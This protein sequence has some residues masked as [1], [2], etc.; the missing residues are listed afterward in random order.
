MIIETADLTIKGYNSGKGVK[1]IHHSEKQIIKFHQLR[2]LVIKEKPI[3][4][5]HCEI[6]YKPGQFTIK[7][8][9]DHVMS[10]KVIIIDEQQHQ[11]LMRF[12]MMDD[13][14]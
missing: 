12:I 3:I 5:T 6:H 7:S 13:E 9:T 10:E 2:D 11:N 8:Y 4:M 1:I 14:L